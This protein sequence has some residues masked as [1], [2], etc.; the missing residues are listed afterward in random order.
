[1]NFEELEDDVKNRL[2]PLLVAEIPNIKVELEPE[3][4]GEN[5]PVITKPRLTIFLGDSDFKPTKSVQYIAQDEDVNLIL[6]ARSRTLR[7]PEGIY[8]IL[9]L[10]RIAMVGYTPKHFSKAWFNKIKM[11]GREH[12]VWSYSLSIGMRGQI[13]EED[14]TVYAKF[15]ALTADH[16][17][18]A[19]NN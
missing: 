8:K 19:L 6:L 7:G 16:E 1:M 3:Y 13:V 18:S 4:E 11:E 2:E 12:G 14:D 10:A 9:E 15:K 5:S 17:D